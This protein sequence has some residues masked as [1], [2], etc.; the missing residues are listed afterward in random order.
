MMTTHQLELQVG[1]VLLDEP[2]SQDVRVEQLLPHVQD[3]Q[4]EIFLLF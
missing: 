1:Q 4:G 2:V 3:V